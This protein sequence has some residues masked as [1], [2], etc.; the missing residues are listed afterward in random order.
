MKNAQTEESLRASRSIKQSKDPKESSAAR[1]RRL[2]EVQSNLTKK[3][4]DEREGAE[5]GQARRRDRLAK[6]HQQ[7]WQQLEDYMQTVRGNYACM[8]SC[9]YLRKS[10]IIL[11]FYFCPIN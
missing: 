1:E 4:I 7:Q 5:N 2:K 9:C 11:P 10:F 3:F 6:V 8:R